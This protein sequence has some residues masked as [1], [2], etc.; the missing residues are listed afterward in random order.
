MSDMKPSQENQPGADLVSKLKAGDPKAYQE[1]MTTYERRI[2]SFAYGFVHDSDEAM[3][4]VQETFLRVFRKVETFKGDSAFTTWLYRIARNLCIDKIRRKKRAPM[5]EFDDQRKHE[6]QTHDKPALVGSMDAY[7][8]VESTLRKELGQELMGA[9]DTLGERHKE[10]LLLRELEGWSYAEIAESM[11]LPIG[12]V[13]SRIYHA[14]K[15]VQHI[16][17]HYLNDRSKGV[18]HG[19]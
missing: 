11:D 9:L 2:Y 6:V 4:I 18:N 12:T 1:L 15:K 19:T 16:L 7:S 3:D 10:V 13:M 17:G 8:P 14:R 5:G